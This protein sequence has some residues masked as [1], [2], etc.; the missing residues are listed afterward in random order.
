LLLLAALLLSA[1][2]TVRIENKINK[3]GSG[4]KSFVL[5]LDKGMMSM[6]ESMAG[7]SGAEAED[8]WEAARLGFSS[9]QGAKVEDYSDDEKEGIQITVP[10]DNLEELQ[11]LSASA[12]FEGSDVV[13]IEQDGDTTTLSATIDTTD[14][15]SAG[16][17]E[18]DAESFEGF[19]LGDIDIEFTYAVEVDGRILEYGPKENAQMAGNKVNWD[20]TQA[21]ADTFDLT[22]SWE[23]SGGPSTATLLLVAAV[24]IG[25]AVALVGLALVVRD[26]RLT[27]G[28]S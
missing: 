12:A 13:T 17:S 15:T 27:S 25:L 8:I 14:M 11:A 10:F 3:D 26:R 23:P 19:D 7:E 6:M 2:V 24:V 5:A 18:A 21:G 20:L 16:L 28:S 9:I 22:I 1:C 4:T